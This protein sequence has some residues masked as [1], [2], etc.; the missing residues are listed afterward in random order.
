MA[1]PVIAAVVRSIPTAVRVASALSLAD[2]LAGHTNHSDVP[3]E[4]CYE[5]ENGEV[6]PCKKC[7][8][9]A[10]KSTTGDN[11]YI[12]MQEKAYIVNFLKHLGEKN[13]ALAHKYLKNVMETKLAKKIIQHKNVRLF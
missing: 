5:D 4:E 3:D 8:E 12:G 6:V 1:L 13:Y 9:K 7:A 10:K 2:K 11:K